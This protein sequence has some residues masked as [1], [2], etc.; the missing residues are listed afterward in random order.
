MSI[1][2][3]CKR[4]YTGKD[5]ICH[6]F[7][8]LYELPTQLARLGHQVTV[9]CL[10]YRNTDH[11]NSFMEDFGS[12]SV[13]WF[14]VPVFSIF[15]FEVRE[16]YQ[17]IK[18]SNPYLII[19]SSDIPCLW[20]TSMLA[21]YCGVNYVVDLYDNY[22]SFGQAR[23]PGFRKVLKSSVREAGA[24][25]VVSSALK[26]KVIDSYMPGGPVLIMNNGVAKSS[27]YEGDRKIARATLGL[28][29]GVKLI[30]TAG[31]L[32]KM[33]GLDTVYEA[34]SRVES[35]TDDVYLVLAGRVEKGFP[36]PDGERVVYLGELPETQVG[37]LF[38]ALDVGII[39][40]HD[41]EF[42]RYCFPQKLYEMLACNL[43]V[44]GARVGSIEAVLQADPNMLFAPGDVDSL[45]ATVLQQVRGPV[46]AVGVKTMEWVDLVKQIEPVILKSV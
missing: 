38:R 26:E 32:S 2:F 17:I 46:L 9:L 4:Y 13:R 8:R 45:V 39:P 42:G 22:E 6:R 24:V 27:F 37:E 11:R 5:V 7:G 36:V 41:S 14:V 19:G 34:W 1:I 29:E 30:G 44:V 40:A 3:V 18:S 15:S 16:A 21:K 31:S 12:G 35:L 33:K 43:P 23:I 28:P 25:I 20:L 10:D